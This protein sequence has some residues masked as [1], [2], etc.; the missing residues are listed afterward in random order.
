MVHRLLHQA[1]S[2]REVYRLVRLTVV[3]SGVHVDVRRLYDLRGL[4][5]HE[6]VRLP[7]LHLRRLLDLVHALHLLVGRLAADVVAF[8]TVV[9]SNLVLAEI[10][11]VNV[12][13]TTCHF[14]LTFNYLTD[15]TIKVKNKQYNRWNGRYI[16]VFPNTVA[17][18][19]SSKNST[20]FDSNRVL[21]LA[22]RCIY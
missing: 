12:K 6:L 3:F 7:L 17:I 18:S 22:F 13:I 19:F 2:V 20:N 8:R 14:Y 21:V 1:G 11:S 16:L 15:R 5:R 10:R 9:G 4:R